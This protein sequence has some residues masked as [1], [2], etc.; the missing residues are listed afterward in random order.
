MQIAVIV[1][2]S[3]YHTEDVCVES[4]VV[5]H[6]SLEEVEALVRDAVDDL[7][8]RNESRVSYDYTVVEYEEPQV[9]PMGVPRQIDFGDLKDW[10][11]ADLG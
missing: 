9:L 8:A 5:E 7:K 10:V 6:H 11:E 4:Y 3:F 1:T 2:A